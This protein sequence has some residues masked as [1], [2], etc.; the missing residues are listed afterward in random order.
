MK[1]TVTLKSGRKFAV[2]EDE[3]YNRCS[4]GGKDVAL[5]FDYKERC[6]VYV[7]SNRDGKWKEQ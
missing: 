4:I 5:V 2:R 3:I 7:I 6:D 1:N